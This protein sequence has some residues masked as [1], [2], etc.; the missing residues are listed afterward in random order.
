[1]E[2]KYICYC[3]LSAEGQAA[4]PEGWKEVFDKED[5]IAKE[6]GVTILSRGIPF[7]VDET[8]VTIYQSEKYIDS[9]MEMIGKTGRNKYVAAARTITVLPFPWER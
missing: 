7:G 2:Y 4:G 9:L 8:W 3:S 6:H 5:E 1:M